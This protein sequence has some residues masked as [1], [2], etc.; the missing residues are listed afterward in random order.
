MAEEKKQDINNEID[1]YSMSDSGTDSDN[2][3]DDDEFK[4]FE[5]ELNRN[6]LEEYHPETKQISYQQINTLSKIVK[7]EQG[8]IIDPLHTTLPF[9]T[10]FEKAKVIGIR[11]KQL[12][13]GAEPLI[14]LPKDVIDGLTIATLEFEQKVLP[15][16][17]RRPLPNGIS[18][19]WNIKDLDIL[20]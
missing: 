14:K 13:N 4:K 2:E 5:Q 16:I 9:I 15:F 20:E 11:A 3:P 10:R 12:N 8:Q 17:I 19:Y 18:E 1:N 6:I 7:N